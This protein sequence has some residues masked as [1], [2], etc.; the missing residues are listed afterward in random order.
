MSI[1]TAIHYAFVLLCVVLRLLEL[2]R[3]SFLHT[4]KP[5]SESL[6]RL[7]GGCTV[8]DAAAM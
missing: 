7:Q 2:R 6:L 1:K 4:G 5:D 3:R 8:T